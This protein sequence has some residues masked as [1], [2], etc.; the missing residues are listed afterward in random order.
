[1]KRSR[2]NMSKFSHWMSFIIVMSL[3]IAY[4]LYNIL[5]LATN[6][7]LRLLIRVY[8]LVKEG[9]IEE[10]YWSGPIFKIRMHVV[11]CMCLIYYLYL[12]IFYS[13]RDRRY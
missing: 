12:V 2:Y 9:L 10:I 11:T 4:I 8:G 13:Y 5:L 1:M 3:T 7:L 6:A